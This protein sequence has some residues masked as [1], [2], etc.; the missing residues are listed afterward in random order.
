[1]SVF[2]Y[3]LKEYNDPP[4]SKLFDFNAL[5]LEVTTRLITYLLIKYALTQ[6]I[7]K[8]EISWDDQ[9][10]LLRIQCSTKKP[11]QINFERKLSHFY[12]QFNILDMCPSNF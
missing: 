5:L 9:V 11:R 4:L 7:E 10:D 12:H 6:Q 3:I 1:M 2:K 8:L